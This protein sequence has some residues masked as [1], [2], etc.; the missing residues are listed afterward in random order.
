MTVEVDKMAIDFYEACRWLDGQAGQRAKVSIFGQV[1]DEPNPSPLSTT[2]L[3]ETGLSV[4][5]PLYGPG[6]EYCLLGDH[7]IAGSFWIGE[8][9]IVGA[10]SRWYDDGEPLLAIPMN[11]EVNLVLLEVRMTDAGW[12][13]RLG[14]EG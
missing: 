2:G 12:L 6:R 7:G 8:E 3:L 5:S 10:I 13:S 9:R 4:A 1:G 11:F 14:E